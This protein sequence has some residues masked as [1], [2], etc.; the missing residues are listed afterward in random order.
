MN[1]YFVSRL[2]SSA[3]TVIILVVLTR[4]LEP[5]DF[6]RYNITMIAGTAAFSVLFAWLATAIHRFHNA[7][8]FRGETIA[9][10]FGAGKRSLLL[11]IPL[12]CLAI[13]LLPVEYRMPVGFGALFCI[14]HAAHELALAGL[15]VNEDRRD[16]ALA[17]LLRPIMGVL[18]VLTFVFFGGGYASAVIGMALAAMLTG[19]YALKQVHKRMKPASFDL[20]AVK[21]FAF[22][23]MP[24]A[25]VAS[26]VSFVALLTQFIL[27]KTIDLE[28][29]G[30]FAAAY[31]LAMR[32][33]AMP[34]TT[35]SNTSAASIFRTF[36]INGHDAAQKELN[37]HF[38]F[39]MLVSAPIVGT[40]IFANDTVAEVVFNESFS[41]RVADHI[42]LLAGA[43]FISG[44]Q[45]AYFSYAFTL[46]KKT[47]HQLMIMISMIAIHA[48]I[49]FGFVASFGGLGASY[50]ILAS[51]IISAAMY[52]VVGRRLTSVRIPRNEILQ[53]GIAML[54]FAPFAIAADFQSGFLAS[55][56]LIFL[57]L[58]AFLIALRVVQ[59]SAF[60]LILA[61]FR[62]IPR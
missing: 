7:P 58:M 4:V 56:S 55:I 10:A 47:L 46:S 26:G 24:L 23:G 15:R 25:V 48:G 21:V 53:T 13:F 14:A 22:F 31:T 3:F 57:G 1:I 45:G 16:F 39:L 8:E 33:I 42:S 20:N 43:A 9:L 54:A 29:V 6:G 5:A 2:F 62:R 38:S 28:T 37:M 34:M 49:A 41:A 12:T 51:A 52:A 60:M 40:L 17:T 61:R 44:I 19:V 59:Q 32:T 35:L 18:F 11:L 30:F 27:A 36:E 50:A